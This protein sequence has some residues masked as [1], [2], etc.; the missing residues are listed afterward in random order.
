[1]SF[2]TFLE[3]KAAEMLFQ[4]LFLAMVIFLMVFYGVDKIFIV[5]LAVFFILHT[6]TQCLDFSI[7]CGCDVFH[8]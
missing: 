8:T 4:M 6:F 5:L 3:E 7:L 1:M 2:F